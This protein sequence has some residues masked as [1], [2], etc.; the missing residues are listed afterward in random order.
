MYYQKLNMKK[1]DIDDVQKF[2]KTSAKY[3]NHMIQWLYYRFY[4]IF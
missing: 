4:I 2:Y 1:H 3:P